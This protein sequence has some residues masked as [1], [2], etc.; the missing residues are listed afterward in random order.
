MKQQTRT[1]FGED[2][3]DWEQVG[4]KN[5]SAVVITVR[6]FQCNLCDIIS[7]VGVYYNIILQFGTIG[8]V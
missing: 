3:E 6:P 1:S 2:P 5:K 8:G 7:V 4:K